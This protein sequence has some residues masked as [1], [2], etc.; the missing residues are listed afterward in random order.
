MKYK[1]RKCITKFCRNDAA[2]N[3]L[4]C[5]KCRSRLYK[6]K[7]PERYSYNILKINARRRNKSFDLTFEQFSE[8]CSETGY[9][10]FKGKDAGS[11]SIDRIDAKKG[12]SKDNLQ[13]LSISDNSTKRHEV[14]YPF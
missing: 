12:Y 2:D 1:R 14:D 4:I 7:H 6:E 11:M 3:R 10:K 13:V 5:H 8:F 9:M